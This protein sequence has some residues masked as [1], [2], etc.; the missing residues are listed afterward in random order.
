MKTKLVYRIVATNGGMFTDTTDIM[1]DTHVQALREAEKVVRAARKE[2]QRP[3]SV[4]LESLTLV[5][6]PQTKD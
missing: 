1:V 3:S 4:Y 5:A 6:R 2:A